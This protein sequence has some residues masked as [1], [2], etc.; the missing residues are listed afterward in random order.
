MRN[1]LFIF[2][3]FLVLALALSACGASPQP[4]TLSVSGNGTV[5]LTPDIAYIYIGIHNEDP[6]VATAVNNNN[7]QTQAL[8]DA[9]KN[10]GIASEDIQT[11]NFSVYTT[12]QYDK[13][14]GVSTGT[15]YAVDNTV[16]VTV[17]DLGKLGT[18]LNTAVSAGANNINSITFDVADKTAA[19]AQARTKAMANASSLAGELAQTAK[20]T[21]G[22]IQTVTYSD[23]SPTPYSSYG[24]GGGGSGLAPNAS[25]PIQPG[26]TQITVTVS[27]T[28]TI[29]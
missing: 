20:V 29:K 13:V 16:Y 18:L 10:A 1:K 2:I 14:T 21:L 19:M 5:F 26:L 25:V 4:R 9:L 17:R 22:E 28:Y 27:V 24:M 8:V 11:S 23:N 7:T 3:P 6:A 15:S 12:S